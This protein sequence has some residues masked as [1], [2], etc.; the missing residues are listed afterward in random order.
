ML[1]DDLRVIRWLRD[2]VIAVISVSF[3][4]GLVKK[5]SLLLLITAG[6]PVLQYSFLFMLCLVV[7]PKM[8]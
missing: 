4:N 6:M 2:D 5:K 3:L 1:S 7:M 8:N